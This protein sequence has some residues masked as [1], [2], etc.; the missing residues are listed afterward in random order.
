MAVRAADTDLGEKRHT[1]SDW[2]SRSQDWEVDKPEAPANEV[3]SKT[4]DVAVLITMPTSHPRF[5]VHWDELGEYAIG[6]LRLSAISAL[7]DS[8]YH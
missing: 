3:T 6:T 8:T 5:V 4:Y 7:D 1:G 2:S